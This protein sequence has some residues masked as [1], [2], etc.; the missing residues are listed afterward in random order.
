MTTATALVPAAPRTLDRV[1]G[2]PGNLLA[3]FLAGRTANTL[4]AY[5]QDLEG[6]RAHLGAS[7]VE[8]AAQVLIAA[9]HGGANGLALLWRAA[10]VDAGLS[11]ATINRRLAALRSLV[12]LA[13]TLGMVPW[14]LEVEGLE[15]KAYRDTRGPGTEGMRAMLGHLAGRQDAKGVR[16]RAVLRCLFDLALR[17]GE[18]T[19]LDMEHLDLAAGTMSVLG[20]GRTSRETLTIPR[21]TLEAIKAWVAMRGDGPGPVFTTMHRGMR[22]RRITGDGLAAVVAEAGTAAGLHVRPHGLRHA[23]ITRALDVTGGNVRDVARFSRHRDVRTLTIYD[24]NRTDLAGKVA[25]AVAFDV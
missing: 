7:T 6:F 18:L 9:G 10:M 25:A 12:K 19:A 5:R 21:P 4:R 22:G 13:R 11:P 1:S 14:T 17:R 2:G 16:D 3:A 23:G 15:A 20:K 8:A 24:D